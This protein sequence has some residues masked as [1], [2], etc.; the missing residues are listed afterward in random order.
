MFDAFGDHYQELLDESDFRED[1][2]RLDEIVEAESE[3]FDRIW[4]NRSLSHDYQLG[5]TGDAVERQRHADI[6]GP[7]RRRVEARFGG[8]DK[9][10]PYTDFGWGMLNGKLSAL[11]W[12]LGSEWDFLDT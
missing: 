1:P 9:L 8:R 7:G 6:A 10:G 2:R 3:L 4:Y 5:E 11:R 12:V